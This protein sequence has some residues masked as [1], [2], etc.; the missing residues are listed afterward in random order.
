[1]YTIRSLIRMLILESTGTK[2]YKMIFLAGLPGGGKSTLLKQLGI[3]DKFTN[4]NID[5]FFEPL[6]DS[7]L[8]T[9]DL[10]TITTNFLKWHSLRKGKLEAGEELS[11]EEIAEY[12]KAAHLNSTQ[13]KLFARA[14]KSF[15]SQLDEVCAIGSNF[16]ID[17]T[18]G[19]YEKTVKS[20][21][22]YRAAGYD[23]A[24][25]FVDIDVETS[26]A[27]NLERGNRGGR[28]LHP[29][30]IRRSNEKMV[31][32]LELYEEFFGENFFLVSNRGTFE[33][34]Q[35]AIEAIRPGIEVFMNS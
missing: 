22:K 13:A 14:I 23:C 18:A 35:A 17:G 9:R 25:V 16:I 8:G 20:V 11:P 33:D 5:N 28:A 31:E 6:L 2:G 3:E 21:E 27:R 10:N 7:E 15:T 34:Y 26:V 19:S 24:M 4:C 32:N 12:E 29:S 1:M 30:I